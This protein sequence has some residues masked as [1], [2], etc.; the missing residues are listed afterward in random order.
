MSL[1]RI[2]TTHAL[3]AAFPATCPGCGREG[4]PICDRCRP[5]FDVR[6]DRPPG[7]PIGMPSDLPVPLLQLEWCAP[8]SGV[9]RQALHAIKYK[10][11]RRLAGPLGGA[12][13]RRWARAGA[14]GNLVVHVPVH[15]ARA[16]RRGYDQ[17][18]LIAAVA[19]RD[20]DLPHASILERHRETIA[21]FD[22]DRRQRS[23]NVRGAFRLVGH[24]RGAPA[25][26]LSAAQPQVLASRWVLLVDDVMTTG[27]TL[28]ACAAVLL[29]AG[30]IGVS[31]ITVARE[32]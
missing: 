25:G 16:R 4:A 32:R 5:A 1:V 9:V 14:G 11:E 12:V 10:G 31:A 8:F 15:A 7:V 24:S 13:A 17:A 26:G 6:L 2:I 28:S 23:T 27:A 3:D 30:A 18:R 22:L 29:E 21:Q 20:L 19:A